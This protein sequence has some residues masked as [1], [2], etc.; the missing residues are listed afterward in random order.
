MTT[1][2][3]SKQHHGEPGCGGKDP[4][5]MAHVQSA[6]IASYVHLRPPNM[7]GSLWLDKDPGQ[8]ISNC[9]I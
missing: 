6:W 1:A 7:S 8:L 9:F 4:T 2:S 3:G 5:P